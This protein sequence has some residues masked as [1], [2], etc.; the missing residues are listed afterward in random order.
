MPVNFSGRL[1]RAPRRIVA[2]HF[3]DSL[4]RRH[5]LLLLAKGLGGG[6]TQ[7]GMDGF[8]GGLVVSLVEPSVRVA[9]RPPSLRQ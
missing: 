4:Q 8:E 7:A 9:K 1:F 5:P 6:D 3:R 2:R